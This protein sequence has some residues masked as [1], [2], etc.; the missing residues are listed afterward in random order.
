MFDS[1]RERRVQS[2]GHQ[3]FCQVMEVV[4]AAWPARLGRRRWRPSG[5]SR[6]APLGSPPPVQAQKSCG[7][8]KFGSVSRVGAFA[9]ETASGSLVVI[10]GAGA[11]RVR[12]R[13][14]LKSDRAVRPV[15]R[16]L[17]GPQNRLV[18]ERS[19]G[20]GV[21]DRSREQ[22]LR[23]L[24]RANEV[25][26]AR[27]K[28]SG[29]SRRGRSSWCRSSLSH[30]VGFVN[31]VVADLQGNRAGAREARLADRV[32]AVTL[33]TAAPPFS[34]WSRAADATRRTASLSKT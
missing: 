6:S 24:E 11:A 15:D 31:S 18:S 7:V 8:R 22:R 14:A 13:W 21:P 12:R 28:L 2:V 23:A 30:P 29:G 32:T 16:R 33:A 5:S 1:G 26:T 20:A 17:A 3:E 9:W 25:R 19:A 10:R 4:G 27:A 34:P